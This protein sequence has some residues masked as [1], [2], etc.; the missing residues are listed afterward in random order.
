MLAPVPFLLALGRLCPNSKYPRSICVHAKVKKR[1][2][3][4]SN[5][6]KR[7]KEHTKK[8][9]TNKHDR[10]G[11]KRSKKAEKQVKGKQKL[12]WQN[13]SDP[14]DPTRLTRNPFDL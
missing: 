1:N 9:K 7:Y 10:H 11:K 4:T 14:L 13:G 12:T 6:R 2:Q 3:Q 8:H 5:G